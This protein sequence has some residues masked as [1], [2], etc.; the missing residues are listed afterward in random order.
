MTL[1]ERE[2]IYMAFLLQLTTPPMQASQRKCLL[3]LLLLLLGVL[4]YPQ[5]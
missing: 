1:N 2:I 5:L 3:L 4:V